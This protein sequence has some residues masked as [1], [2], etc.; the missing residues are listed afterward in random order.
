MP[1]RY[2]DYFELLFLKKQLVQETHSDLLC[3]PESNKSYASYTRR[4]RDILIT[5]DREFMAKK[6]V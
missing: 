2:A 3:P 4:K 1:L 6:T 5:R